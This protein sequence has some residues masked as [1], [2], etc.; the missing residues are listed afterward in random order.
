M[1]PHSVELCYDIP[2]RTFL[3]IGVFLLS[4]YANDRCGATSPNEMQGIEKIQQIY[5]LNWP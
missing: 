5:I 1:I 4:R 3:G 2:S